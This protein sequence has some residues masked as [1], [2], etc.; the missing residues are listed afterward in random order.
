[1][2][3]VSTAFLTALQQGAPQRWVFAWSDGTL[4]SNEDIS[5][6]DG[7]S[8][9]ETFCSETDLTV[10][11]TPSARIAFT[12]L[13]KD[14]QWQDFGF[15]RFS[16]Y[17]GVR[18]AWEKNNSAA[19]RRPAL[20]LNGTTLTVN[21]NGRLETY[22]MAP[23]GIFN[24]DRPSIMHK[25]LISIEAMDLMQ[26]FEADMPSASALNISYPVTAKALLTA[27]CGYLG[28]TLGSDSWLNE[29]LTLA[30]APKQ[31]TAATMRDVLGYIAEA[32]C[33]VARFNRQGQLVL[34]WL[35]RL[36][37]SYDEHSYTD[38]EY[39]DYSTK[40]VNKLS[41]RNEDS[42]QQ[43]VLSSGDGDSAYMIQDNPFLTA[44]S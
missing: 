5:V 8:F 25:T 11:L 16:A 28:V 29:G 19:V 39:T 35:N 24:A 13:N 32:A 36:Q 14:Y 44:S 3:Q 37:R 20:A 30:K 23:F 21:G 33:A 1:M 15:G 6:D 22:E 43:T 2:I 27:M 12:L 7:V 31:F 4:M 26:L 40:A 41:V 38:F 42:T 34:V 18:T 10:G 17:L 9:D